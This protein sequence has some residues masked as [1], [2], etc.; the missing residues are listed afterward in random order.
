[1]KIETKFVSFLNDNSSQQ[2]G[3]KENNLKKWFIL[4]VN[5]LQLKDC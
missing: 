5:Q 4:I 1:M 3:L 2:R